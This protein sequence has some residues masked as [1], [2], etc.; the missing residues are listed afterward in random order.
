MSSRENKYSKIAIVSAMEVELEYADRFLTGRE[1]WVKLTENSYQYLNGTTVY[2]RVVG[3]G[4]V[5]SAFQTSDVI[6][7]YHPDL[8]VNVGY[9]GGLAKGARKGDVAIGTDYVQV[10]FYPFIGQR[11]PE[12]ETPQ[13]LIDA[14]QKEAKELEIPVFTGKIATG[15]FFL[16]S[17]EEK[18]RIISE[19][20][21]I[22]FDMESAAIAQVAAYKNVDFAVLRTF[23]D[24]ADDDA[25][26]SITDT[27]IQQENIKISIEQRPIVLLLSTLEKLVF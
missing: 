18:K 22:A 12:A 6:N 23:S 10:D 1:G 7:E 25:L 9:A 16:H 14:L 19:F 26:D 21:P 3:A 8:V 2:T 17:A 5:N 11:P 24:L 13:F 15:D 20:E 4:K 27:S